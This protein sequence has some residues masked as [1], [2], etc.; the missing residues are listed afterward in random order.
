MVVAVNVDNEG[1]LQYNKSTYHT[2]SVIAVPA[3]GAITLTR[4]L[5]F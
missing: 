2:V 3:D 5:Y 4:M 1:M